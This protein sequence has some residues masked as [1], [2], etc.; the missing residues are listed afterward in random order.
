MDMPARPLGEPVADGFG[1][2]CGIDVHDEMH[3]EIIG[4]SSLDLIREASELLG[5]MASNHAARGGIKRRE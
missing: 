3:I 4:D 5:P 2:V 1:L